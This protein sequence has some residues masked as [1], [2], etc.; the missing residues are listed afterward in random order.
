[1]EGVVERW[2]GVSTMRELVAVVGESGLEE[3]GRG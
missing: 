3:V 1:M 2:V